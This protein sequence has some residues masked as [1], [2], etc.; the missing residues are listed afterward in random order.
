MIID[1]T[2]VLFVVEKNPS[3]LI[4]VARRPHEFGLGARDIH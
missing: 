3:P 4:V 2:H 1:D